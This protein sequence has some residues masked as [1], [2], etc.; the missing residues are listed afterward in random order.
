MRATMTKP[1][2]DILA[3]KPQARLRVYRCEK[4]T[5]G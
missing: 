3:E 1:I 2:A 4:A 5:S